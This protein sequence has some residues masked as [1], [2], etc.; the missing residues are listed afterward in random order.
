VISN[1]QVLERPG[2]AQISQK[3]DDE[4]RYLAIGQIDGKRIGWQSLL[5]K[6]NDYYPMRLARTEGGTL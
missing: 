4:P 5:P 1:V 6:A 3:T 2:A